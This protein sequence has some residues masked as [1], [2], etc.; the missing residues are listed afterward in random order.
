MNGVR[1]RQAMCW[2]PVVLNLQCVSESSTGCLDIRVPGLHTG[3]SDLVGL[4]GGVA[5]LTS[6]LM[7]LVQEIS[8]EK[9]CC[10]P[11]C[12]P[13]TQ[14]LIWGKYWE[15]R[16]SGEIHPR[17]IKNEYAVNS[18]FLTDDSPSEQNNKLSWF[19]FFFPFP[20][21]LLGLE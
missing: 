6:S 3:D 15:I 17:S 21:W 8:F 10:T 14:A 1:I 20:R 2:R 12:M 16:P 11:I 13:G 9:Y 5:F 4:G 7:L 18:V 19:V